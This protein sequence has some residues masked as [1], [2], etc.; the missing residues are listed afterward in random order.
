M[1][2][3]DSLVAVFNISLIITNDLAEWFREFLHRL[4]AD[5]RVRDQRTIAP[6]QNQD[7]TS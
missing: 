5:I 7:C 1:C 2:I 3:R 4:R 6:V